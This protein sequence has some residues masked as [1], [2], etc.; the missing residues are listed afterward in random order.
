VKNVIECADFIFCNED[1]AAC[2][3]KVMNIEYTS[4][5]EVACILAKSKKNNT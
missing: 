3:A 5:K 1:E 4:L 2:Y